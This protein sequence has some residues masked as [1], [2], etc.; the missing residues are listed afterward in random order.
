MRLTLGVY[1]L[2]LLDEAILFPINI[3]QDLLG[4]TD[5]LQTFLTVSKVH[6][7]VGHPLHHPGHEVVIPSHLSLQALAGGIELYQCHLKFI[8]ARLRL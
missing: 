3:V 2:S 1:K 6:L 7:D 8:T 4:L 5:Q